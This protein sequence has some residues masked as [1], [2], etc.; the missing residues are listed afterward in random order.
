MHDDDTDAA[1]TLLRTVWAVQN[2]RRARSR[3]RP[4]AIDLGASTQTGK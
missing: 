1:P 2:R 4:K 3:P